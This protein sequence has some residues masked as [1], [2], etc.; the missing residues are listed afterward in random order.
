MSKILSPE[1]KANLLEVLKQRFEKH[2]TWY[3]NLDW[4]S[5]QSKLDIN[6]AKLLSLNKMELTGGEPA[7]IEYRADS[8]VFIFF[9]CSKESPSGRRSLCYD[10]AALNAQSCAG[11]S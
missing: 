4:K 5:V 3:P 7:L 8:G 10:E 6:D 1:V 11:L 9:D 2:L